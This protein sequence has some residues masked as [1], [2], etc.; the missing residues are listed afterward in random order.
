MSNFTKV[1]FVIY[2][3]GIVR[4]YTYVFLTRTFSFVTFT[5]DISSVYIYIVL[6]MVYSV[7]YNLV[8]C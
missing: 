3:R 8:C 6:K 4:D 7:L 1:L 2:I 5:Y